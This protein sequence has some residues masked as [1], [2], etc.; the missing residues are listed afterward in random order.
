MYSLK[1]ARLLQVTL[2]TTAYDGLRLH[3]THG[4]SQ[5][6]THYLW[7]TTIDVHVFC[8]YILIGVHTSGQSWHSP[9]GKVHYCSNTYVKPTIVH[10]SWMNSLFSVSDVVALSHCLQLTTTPYDCCTWCWP[11]CNFS[12][13]QVWNQSRRP[14]QSWR[15]TS[16]THLLLLHSVPIVLLFT[17]TKLF[18]GAT[19]DTV[20]IC[21]LD[22]L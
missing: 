19:Y 13:L 11:V 8:M 20:D 3:T 10:K 21:Q 22:F 7:L 15:L 18:N 9:F 1:S 2:P 17:V 12:Q 16:T 14:E 6:P 5:L 4:Y